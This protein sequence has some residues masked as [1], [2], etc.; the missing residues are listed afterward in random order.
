MERDPKINIFT[1][2]NPGFTAVGLCYAACLAEGEGEPEAFG[3][4]EGLDS[5]MMEACPRT[6]GTLLSLAR[7]LGHAQEPQK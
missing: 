4:F 6:N 1:N 2:F 5:V 3:A 7:T